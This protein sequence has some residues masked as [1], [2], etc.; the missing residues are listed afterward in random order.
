[1]PTP[2]VILFSDLCDLRNMFTGIINGQGDVLAVDSRQGE[3][4]LVIHARYD[5]S[6]IVT[7]ESIAVN[8]VCLTVEKAEYRRFT[9]YASAET[10]ARTNLGSLRAGTS[11]VNLER[12]LAVGDRLGGHIVSG[13]VDCVARVGSIRQKGES[14]C[15][16]VLFP[17]CLGPEVIVKGSV[18]LDGIS[19]TVNDCGPGFLDVNVIPETWRETTVAAWTTGSHINMETDLLGKYVRQ[20]LTPYLKKDIESKDCDM[21]DC[22]IQEFHEKKIRS[23]HTISLDFLRENGFF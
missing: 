6:D 7:G 9:A 22:A 17:A 13:H 3:A 1:M 16:R 10:M 11:R 20:M 15:I 12:A 18:A 8:G 5:L 19:L 14:R 2:I 21:E 23:Q 4:R